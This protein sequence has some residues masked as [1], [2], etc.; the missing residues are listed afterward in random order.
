[1]GQNYED[2]VANVVHPET[3]TLIFATIAILNLY[4]DCVNIMMAFLNT[5]MPSEMPIFV[6]PP[7]GYQMYNDQ[8]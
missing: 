1:L 7:P 8:G 2:T 4:A 6:S 3:L 5:L